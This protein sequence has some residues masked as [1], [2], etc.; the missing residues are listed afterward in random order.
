MIDHDLHDEIDGHTWDVDFPIYINCTNQRGKYDE[1]RVARQRH[2]RD[3]P[4]T[5]TPR[6]AQKYYS[7][8]LEY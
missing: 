5:E 6:Q 8:R 7:Q 2:I 3:A 4:F 1:E